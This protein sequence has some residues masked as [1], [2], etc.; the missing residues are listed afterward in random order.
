MLPSAFAEGIDTRLI[1]T[2]DDVASA[3]RLE[4]YRRRGTAGDLPVFKIIGAAAEAGLALDA[5]ETVGQRANAR[6]RSFGVAFDGCTLP[7]EKEKLFHVP[8]GRLALGLGVHGEPGI[9]ELDLMRP[10]E[11]AAILC[12]RLLDEAPSDAGSR[13]TAVLNGLGSTKYEELFVLWEAIIPYLENAGYSIIAPL[14]GEYVTSLDMA[15]CSLTLTW[16]D[17]ELEAFWCAPVTS[18]ALR[19]ERVTGQESIALPALI[20]VPK[21]VMRS[22]T[23]E[24]RRGGLCVARAMARLSAALAEA[25]PMLG[26]IDAHAGDGD[27]GQSMARGS[28]AAAKAA[29][30]A[31]GAGAGPSTVLMAAADAWAD[32]A[33]GTSGALWGAGLFEFSTALDDRAMPEA[34][35]L[36][37]GLRRARDKIAALGKAKPGDKTLID[38]LTPLVDHFE[39]GIEKGHTLSRAWCEA[40]KASTDAAE[41]TKELLPRLGRA[42]LHGER[43]LGQPDAGAVSMAFCARV[44][45]ELL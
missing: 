29:R 39:A 2:T 1:A 15:G 28:D 30:T 22:Q 41:A 10:E 6:T 34:Q 3:P 11:L 31:V 37:L 17:E 12:E 16:L 26:K 23:D 38:A 13:I 27:H 36:A 32:R 42:R 21:T 25:E 5:V 33:G 20:D 35:H 4:H 40:A 7:G 19:R 43:S 24:G 18:A 9:D 8:E 44:I 45:G 14:A